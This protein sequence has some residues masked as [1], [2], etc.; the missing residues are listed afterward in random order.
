MQPAG[1]AKKVA[2]KVWVLLY[3]DRLHN[4]NHVENSP[5]FGDRKL[6]YRPVKAE[7]VFDGFGEED[8]MS[9]CHMVL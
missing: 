1:Y 5:A 8:E 7:L 6:R 4:F 9:F 2:T 3:C